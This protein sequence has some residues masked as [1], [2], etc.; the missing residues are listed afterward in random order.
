MSS[1]ST[2]DSLLP[3]S[4]FE[5]SWDNGIVKQT[6]NWPERIPSKGQ[7]KNVPKKSR[8]EST[9]LKKNYIETKGGKDQ[10]AEEERRKKKKDLKTIA[11][12][13]KSVL[14]MHAQ[15]VPFLCESK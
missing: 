5:V 11:M 1:Y 12:N 3:N 15:S 7:T 14:L 9:K 10:E 4:S 8:N 13:N 2:W 6:T